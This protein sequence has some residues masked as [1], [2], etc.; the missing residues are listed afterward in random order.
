MKKTFRNFAAIIA[1]LALALNMFSMSAFASDLSETREK[2]LKL[3]PYVDELERLSEGYDNKLKICLGTPDEISMAY[4]AY[5][6]MTMDDFKDY[7]IYVYNTTYEYEPYTDD[8]ILLSEDFG[9]CGYIGFDG[10][11]SVGGVMPLD[12]FRITNNK[13]KFFYDSAHL[14]NY[15]YIINTLEQN[16]QDIRTYHS[17]DN[18]GW[19]IETYPAYKLY[20][21]TYYALSS[22]KKSVSCT[23]YAYR[24]VSQT[25]YYEIEKKFTTTFSAAYGDVYYI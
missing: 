22:D 6:S 3:Q 9:Q 25:A 15:F 8:T 20:K 14:G 4:D 1:T 16:E 19:E 10:D 17:I 12:A 11:A 13:Q 2:L 24:Y 21:S 7:F 18:S 5:C 23:F